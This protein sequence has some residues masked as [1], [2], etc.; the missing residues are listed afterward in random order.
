MANVML[1]S[2]TAK[3]PNKPFKLRVEDVC[4]KFDVRAFYFS[5]L[6]VA[7]PYLTTFPTMM[8]RRWWPSVCCCCSRRNS[9]RTDTSAAGLRSGLWES[10]E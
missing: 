2:E 3:D 9:S 1:T 8:H 4:T 7:L 5:G 10:N 6:V